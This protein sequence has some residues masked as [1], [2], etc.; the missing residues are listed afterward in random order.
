M[1]NYKLVIP[2][3]GTGSRIGPL[4]K[5]VNKALVTLGDLPAVVRIILQ[6]QEDIELVIPLGYK[7]SHIKQVLNTFFPL[8]KISYVTI[9]KFDGEGSGLGYTLN[10]V[11][12]LLQCPFIF[13]PND[14]LIKVGNLNLNPNLIGN[15]L[16]V[17]EKIIGD[18]VPV[19]QYRTVSFENDKM[20]SINPKG[21]DDRNIYTGL[22]G[23]KEYEVFWEKM[24]SNESFDVGESFGLN[25]LSQVRVFCFKEWWDT[26]NLKSI[27]K[28]QSFYKNKQNNILEKENEAIWFHGDKVIKFHTN[29]SFI[30]ERVERAKEMNK[31]LIPKI[32]GQSDNL[33][34]YK[35]IEG[36]VL[37]KSIDN[38]KTKDL[39]DF[40]YKFMW[41]ESRPLDLKEDLTHLNNFYK[42]KTLSRIKHYLSRFEKDDNEITINGL[43]CPKIFDLIEEINWQSFYSDT[44]LA[45]F[46]GDFHSENIL[47]NNS[48][49]K[50]I[51]WRQD[52]GNLGRKYGDVYYDLGKFLHG[53]IVSHEL[54]NKQ[55]F[56]VT[57]LNK[58]DVFINIYQTLSNI[59]SIQVF[60]DWCESNGYNIHKVK[61]TTALIYLNIAGLHHYPYSEF[62]FLLGRK[63]LNQLLVSNETYKLNL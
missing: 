20:H 31:I 19:E 63:M 49:F 29:K 27:K 7:A 34:W 36:S 5:N 33:F 10:K 53:L 35:K 51:D 3:A 30:S 17:Y 54:V 40:A 60:Y 48:S 28:A 25:A 56:S 43:Y 42:E 50:F 52:F 37:S 41:S 24:S 4:T 1:E 61:L 13:C 47:F 26:G 46:H 45:K 18:E 21:F 32:E 44:I 23:I 38:T 57:Y 12:H 58:N 39:L 2:C 55:H 62:L 9:D 15:W 11:K 14:S 22:C 59:E 6:F 8:R 16:G